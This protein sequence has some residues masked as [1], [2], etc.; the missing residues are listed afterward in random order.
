[1]FVSSA[2]LGKE[3]CWFQNLVD[4]KQQ[5]LF[6]LNFYVHFGLV[7]NRLISFLLPITAFLGGGLPA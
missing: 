4:K 6:A 3:K 5:E 7:S 2:F 1:M